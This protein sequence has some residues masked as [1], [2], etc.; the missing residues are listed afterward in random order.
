MGIPPQKYFVLKDGT[1][2]KN[3]FELSKALDKMPDATFKHHVSENRNDFA[4]W[5]REV[6]KDMS[7]AD[8]MASAKTSKQLQKA[9]GEKIQ[10]D[11]VKA[12]G[13]KKHTKPIRTKPKTKRKPRKTRAK[14]AI[15]KKEVT[16]TLKT[17]KEKL[18][19]FFLTR[20]EPKVNLKHP[21]VNPKKTKF[22]VNCPYKTFHCGA[23]EFVFG[24]II[25]LLAALVLTTL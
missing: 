12:I 24:L 20:E 10:T 8:K 17:F 2:I 6:V 5:V 9:I 16:K 11:V 22:G 23:L 21:Y 3:L 1:V 14:K 19:N 18:H 7:L 15:T 4:N 25:G 13:R